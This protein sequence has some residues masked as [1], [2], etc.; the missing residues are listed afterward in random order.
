[1]NPAEPK[2]PGNRTFGFFFAAVFS[3]A[4]LYALYLGANPYAC[5][6][7]AVAAI[8]LLLALVKA[9]WLLPLNRL[10]LRFGLL[11]G[12]IISPIVLGLIFFGLFMPIGLLMRAFG[13]DELRLKFRPGQTLWR[14]KNTPA[15]GPCV[16]TRQF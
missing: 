8:L 7:F 5:G 4:G 11:L 15:N 3:A 10:W 2:L 6:A 1:M 13:R 12:S 16:F 9:E 14:P